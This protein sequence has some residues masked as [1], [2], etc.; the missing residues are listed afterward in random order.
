MYDHHLKKDARDPRVV[1]TNVKLRRALVQF[2]Q[3]HTLKDLSVQKITAMAGVTRGTFYL[4]YSDKEDFVKQ[5]QLGF[6]HHFFK[7][8][9]VYVDSLE[10]LQAFPAFNVSLAFSFISEHATTFDVFLN[11][12]KTLTFNDQFHAGLVSYFEEYVRKSYDVSIPESSLPE[13]PVFDFYAGA[14]ISLVS[15]WL[16]DNKRYSSDYMAHIFES[17]LCADNHDVSKVQQFF[18]FD[19]NGLTHVY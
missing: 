12:E 1:K 10:A 5:I 16:K 11:R 7:Q 14:F 8:V 18:T 9:I 2:L 19:K 3:Y 13:K 4:H 17:L 6:L 15:N